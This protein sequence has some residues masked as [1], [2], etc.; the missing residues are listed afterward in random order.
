MWYQRQ[1]GSRCSQ[2]GPASSGQPPAARNTASRGARPRLS[3]PA[4][5]VGPTH[6]TVF[7][8]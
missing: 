8:C 4:V 3:N 5:S 7:I 1:S 6:N 2:S